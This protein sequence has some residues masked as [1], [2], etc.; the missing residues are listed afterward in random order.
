MLGRDLPQVL[1]APRV[2]KYDLLSQNV[3]IFSKILWAGNKIK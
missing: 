3:T 1:G 2:P